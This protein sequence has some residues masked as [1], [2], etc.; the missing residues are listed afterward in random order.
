MVLRIY[1]G[2]L[3]EDYGDMAR[4]S[5]SELEPAVVKLMMQADDGSKL[6][7]NSIASL[8][9]PADDHPAKWPP[10]RGCQLSLVHLSGGGPAG[11]RAGGAAS[12]C[13]GTP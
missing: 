6:V 4:Q 9:G 7:A 3:A 11:G 13:A 2:K 5:G 8:G 10:D 1:F 12:P